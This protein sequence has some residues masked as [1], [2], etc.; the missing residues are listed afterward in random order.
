MACDESCAVAGGSC[1]RTADVEVRVGFS[2]SK[3]IGK[4]RNS[5]WCDKFLLLKKWNEA[6]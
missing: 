1:A 4:N 6:Q 2:G 3:R 5:V